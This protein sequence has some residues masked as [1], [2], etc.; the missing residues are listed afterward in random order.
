MQPNEISPNVDPLTGYVLS[1]SVKFIR[2]ALN[3]IGAYTDEQIK[4]IIRQRNYFITYTCGGGEFGDT[5]PYLY[6]FTPMTHQELNILTEQITQNGAPISA[7]SLEA[8]LT[9]ELSY[10]AS[11]G[12]CN[13]ISIF[14]KEDL[15][16]DQLVRRAPGAYTFST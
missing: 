1:E 14:S 16:N 13:D 8:I 15:S 6:S 7:A 9:A 12:L 2:N 4:F 10:A 3:G 11:A 5:N